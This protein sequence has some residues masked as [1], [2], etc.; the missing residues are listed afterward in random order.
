MSWKNEKTRGSKLTAFDQFMNS[1]RNFRVEANAYP[2]S[3][4]ENKACL[5]FKKLHGDRFRT[6]SGKKDPRKG[7]P[8]NGPAK[9]SLVEFFLRFAVIFLKSP[10]NVP[11][12]FFLVV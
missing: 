12:S 10:V 8:I 4:E 5:L 7:L 9:S 2:C 6:V 3:D 11:V 1:L